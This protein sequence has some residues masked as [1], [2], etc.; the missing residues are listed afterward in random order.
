MISI[1]IENHHQV[2]SKQSILAR[3][4]GGLLP[5]FVRR[6]VEERIGEIIRQGLVERG[7]QATITITIVETAAARGQTQD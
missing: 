1:Q 7:V 2:A 3:A 5:R 6:K 4:V